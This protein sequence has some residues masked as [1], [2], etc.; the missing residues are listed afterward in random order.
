M[1]AHAGEKARETGTFHCKSCDKTVHVKK[2]NTIPE[3]PCGGKTFDRR[4]DEPGNKSSG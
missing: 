2:G 3:C 4:T 1:A